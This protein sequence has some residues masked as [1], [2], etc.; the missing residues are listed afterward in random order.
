MINGVPDLLS[1]L[2]LQTGGIEIRKRMETLSAEIGSGRKLSV[3]EA[4][5]GD[6]VRL[7][8]LEG[9]ISRLAA[10][11]DRLS[12][13][14]GRAETMQTALGILQ[15]SAGDLGVAVLGAIGLGDLSGARTHASGARDAFEQA[16]GALNASLGGRT[17]FSGA[18]VDGPALADA[19]AMLASITAAVDAT[20]NT[21]DALAAIETWFEDPAGGFATMGYVGA[22]QDAPAVHLGEDGRLGYALRA[23]MAELRDMLRGLATLVIAAEHPLAADLPAAGGFFQTGGERLI[24]ARDGIAL[25][26][27]ALGVDQA[28]IEAS[29]TATAAETGALE[30]LRARLVARDPFEAASDFQALEAQMQSVYAVTARLSGLSLTNFL[31]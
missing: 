7:Y 9:A 30:I 5:G 2:R 19:T 27:S 12:M 25:V 21:T 24:A 31:R 16:V 13:A 28:R 26:R 4:S 18:A 17:L 10:R 29:A 22:D 11:S 14:E 1:G 8:A 6:P 20:A 23:D 15:D 3:M